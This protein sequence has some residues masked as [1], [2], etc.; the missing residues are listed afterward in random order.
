MSMFTLEDVDDLVVLGRYRLDKTGEYDISYYE[1]YI[2]EN[3]TIIEELIKNVQNEINMLKDENVKRRISNWARDLIKAYEINKNKQPR[4]EYEKSP[5]LEALAAGYF[6]THKYAYFIQRDFPEVAESYSKI[7]KFMNKVYEHERLSAKNGEVDCS[8]LYGIFTITKQACS[9]LGV[10]CPGAPLICESITEDPDAEKSELL[11]ME[12][13]IDETNSIE[14]DVMI[15]SLPYAVTAPS[16]T[17]E[18]LRKYE[19]SVTDPKP[20]VWYN[21][22]YLKN[23]PTL[24]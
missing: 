7:I 20:N 1:N 13:Q 6:Q 15:T 9:K 24:K 21:Q 5:K 14:Q 2:N 19:L 22:S 8:T 12:V 23:N 16:F 11:G 10:H 18:G 3:I 17:A 4:I